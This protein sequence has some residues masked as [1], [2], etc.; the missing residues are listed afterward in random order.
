MYF[1][2]SSP[3]ETAKAPP[4]KRETMSLEVDFLG[5]AF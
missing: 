5:P 2:N 3:N 4:N 1:I